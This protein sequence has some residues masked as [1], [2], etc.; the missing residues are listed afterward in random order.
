[1]HRANKIRNSCK[2][3]NN[4]NKK[5][6]EIKDFIREENYKIHE[7]FVKR[8]EERE[9]THK[10]VRRI[11]FEGVPEFSFQNRVSFNWKKNRVVI[12]FN[13][14]ENGK[15]LGITLITIF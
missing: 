11:I 14:K 8:F 7:H 13:D 6:K 4:K 12:E 9:F 5:V 10:E 3:K 1:M 2:R 15:I